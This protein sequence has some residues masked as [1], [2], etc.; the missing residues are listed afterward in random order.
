MF[1]EPFSDRVSSITNIVSF[2]Q[3][4][5]FVFVPLLCNRR[6][7]CITERTHRHVFAHCQEPGTTSWFQNDVSFYVTGVF[8]LW[9]RACSTLNSFALIGCFIDWPFFSSNT[10]HFWA[11]ANEQ[12][13]NRIGLSLRNARF[14][15]RRR[16]IPYIFLMIYIYAYLYVGVSIPF[17]A[18]FFYKWVVL[19]KNILPNFTI[20]ALFT[21]FFIDTK[22]QST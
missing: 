17:P 19:K 22:S 10:S 5:A 9:A 18:P 6:F 1:L 12:A 2:R 4:C 20:G 11:R 14:P 16:N 8:L 15:R 3:T 13:V 21:R 7:S